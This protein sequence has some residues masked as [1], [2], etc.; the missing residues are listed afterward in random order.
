MRS[1]QLCVHSAAPGPS[2]EVADGGRHDYVTVVQGSI[3][4]LPTSYNFLHI[5]CVQK[6]GCSEGFRRAHSSQQRGGIPES[7]LEEMISES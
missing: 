5:D 7:F 3:R 1:A 4:P 2:E 6:A